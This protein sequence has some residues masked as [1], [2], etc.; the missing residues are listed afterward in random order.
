MSRVRAKVAVAQLH[1]EPGS[2]GE[3]MQVG[4]AQPSTAGCHPEVLPTKDKKWYAGTG[5]PQTRSDIQSQEILANLP[6]FREP[7]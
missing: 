1:S 2:K 4:S 7:L 6:R 5:E 3:G